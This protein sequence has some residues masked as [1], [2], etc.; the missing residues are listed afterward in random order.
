MFHHALQRL[1]LTYR[2]IVPD[3]RAKLEP[4]LR[5]VVPV[6]RAQFSSYRDPRA[7]TALDR[8]RDNEPERW[9]LEIVS[10]GE[11]VGGLASP[12]S[13]FGDV[14]QRSD[15]V[16]SFLMRGF[17]LP[18]NLAALEAAMEQAFWSKTYQVVV[19]EVMSL[20]E[21]AII[22]AW[23]RLS[24]Y[25][26]ISRDIDDPNGHNWKFLAEKLLP[27]ILS[28]HVGDRGAIVRR[29]VEA[30]QIRHDVIHKGH[31]PTPDQADAVASTA[32]LLL[33]ILEVPNAF[34]GNWHLR[35]NM[36]EPQP[37]EAT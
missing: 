1:L 12:S 18:Q 9:H 35:P 11:Y 13:R 27:L 33:S 8:I 5:G 28:L 30:V 19:V 6:V 31:Q 22:T 17:I 25:I 36:P 7:S 24:S 14:Q 29:I 37:I 4:A 34:K 26:T 20:V 16:G 3:L 2:Y 21:L 32:R 10:I 15:Q 23:R